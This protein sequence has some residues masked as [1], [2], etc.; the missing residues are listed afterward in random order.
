MGKS[1]DLCSLAGSMLVGELV[2]GLK[3][4]SS[5]DSKGKDL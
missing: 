2:E 3:S 4:L 1:D 5:I